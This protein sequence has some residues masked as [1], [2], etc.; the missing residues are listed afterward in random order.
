MRRFPERR[1]QTVQPAVNIAAAEGVALLRAE[2]VAQRVQLLD[3]KL[4]RQIDDARAGGRNQIERIAQRLH[5]AHMIDQR[6]DHIGWH[7]LLMPAAHQQDRESI[8]NERQA[9]ARKERLERILF[10][11]RACDRLIEEVLL[12]HVA[13]HIERILKELFLIQRVLDCG[14]QILQLALG[15]AVVLHVGLFGERLDGL[16]ERLR[17]A[18]RQHPRQQH[19]QRDEQQVYADLEAP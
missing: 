17:V 11:H 2:A 3:R 1:M 13:A 7:R 18:P 19:A 15:A 6:R 5:I 10:L 9:V 14:A 16:L 12:E 8:G 4:D